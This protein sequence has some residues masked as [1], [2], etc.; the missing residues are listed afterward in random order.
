MI[1]WLVIETDT[2]NGGV[3][4]VR[5]RSSKESAVDLCVDIAREDGFIDA[6]NITEGV[7]TAMLLSDLEYHDGDILITIYKLEV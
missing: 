2:I 6:Q 4:N 1:L 7:L 5:A 3:R